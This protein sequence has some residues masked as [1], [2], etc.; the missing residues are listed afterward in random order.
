MVFRVAEVDLAEHGANEHQV[1][2]RRFQ[3]CHGCGG[4]HVRHVARGFLRVLCRLAVRQHRQLHVI[5]HA[6][7]LV[8]AG[9]VDRR[10]FQLGQLGGERVV[11]ARHPRHHRGDEV[12]GKAIASTLDLRE[13]VHQQGRRRQG[14][15]GQD[16]LGIADVD[17]P[18]RGL[19]R[20]GHAILL[21]DTFDNALGNDAQR[22]AG[23][24]GGKVGLFAR[25]FHDRGRGRK[26]GEVNAAST[27][28]SGSEWRR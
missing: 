1:I 14:A 6:V 26:L 5:L 18:A 9:Q 21:V 3:L 17:H 12:R 4:H 15:H 16:Q 23:A 28:G 25:Q 20:S 24:G 10:Q 22:A 19:Q 7:V 27:I 13:R 8:L 11:L 2:L